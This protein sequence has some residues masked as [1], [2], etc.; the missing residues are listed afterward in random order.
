MVSVRKRWYNLRCPECRSIRGLK[1]QHGYRERW[2]CT[3]CGKIVGRNPE[4]YTKWVIDYTDLAGKRHLETCPRNW[5][6][7]EARQR[8]AELTNEPG[9]NPGILFETVV[10]EWLSFCLSKVVG[11]R[12]RPQSYD[13][14]RRKARHLLDRFGRAKIKDISRAQILD[15]LSGK[16]ADGYAPRM[17]SEIRGRL[18]AIFEFAQSRD[19][20]ASNPM[21]GISQHL[22]LVPA[23]RIDKVLALSDQE[24]EILLD[25]AVKDEEFYPLL[26]TLD[27]SGVR[28][29]ELS[30]LRPEDVDLDKRDLR[31][32]K[33]RIARGD[34]QDKPKSRASERTVDMSHELCD[35][36]ARVLRERNDRRMREGWRDFA[37]E[38]FLNRHGRP[39][40]PSKIAARFKKIVKSANLPE[41]FTPH[42]MRHTF[43][44]RHLELGAT[45]EWLSRQMGHKRIGITMD[46]YG[47]WAQ[48]S[49]KAAA[50]RLDDGYAAKQRRLEWEA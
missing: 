49:D 23:S 37:P 21:T 45:A 24:R 34:V 3:Q 22:A 28:V 38:L 26:F 41:H 31:I 20:V 1:K 15:L 14:Y 4:S 42:S 47:R 6:K 46:L 33:T 40:L 16:L 18:W 25:A 36:L 5:S 39:W 17:V 29:G 30:A 32:S 44:R 35:M 12:L 11:D 27:R 50:D 7:R 8:A 48:I 2:Q 13:D 10:R 19:Y 9:H 43:A